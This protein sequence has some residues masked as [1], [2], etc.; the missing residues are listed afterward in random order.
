MHPGLFFILYVNRVNPP[1][2]KISKVTH[3]TYDSAAAYRGS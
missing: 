2:A 1:P 3:P